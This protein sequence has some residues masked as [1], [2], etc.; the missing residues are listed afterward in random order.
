[1]AD[2]QL[3]LLG[4]FAGLGVFLGLPLAA[5]QKVSPKW[6]GFLNAFATGILIF[7]M[8]DA[9]GDAWQS[10]AHTAFNAFEGQ[11][12]VSDAVF[13]VLA[14]FGGLLIGLF[15]LAY[16]NRYM[17]ILVKSVRSESSEFHG[18]LMQE[19]L[20]EGVEQVNGCRLSLIIALGIG[21]HNFNEGLKLG[22]FYASGP[23]GLALSLSLLIG[24]LLHGA[25]KG[26]GI[27]GPL[28]GLSKM[29]SYRLLVATA[30]IC[31]LP[32]L[33]GTEIGGL[34]FSGLFFVFFM[35]VAAGALVYATAMQTL[36]LRGPVL[37]AVSP[38]YLLMYTA[39]KRQ[40]TNRILV[41]GVFFG[42]MAALTSNLLI[43]ISGLL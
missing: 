22:H 40:V 16:A 32:T 10:I 20:F 27:A 8:V 5:L 26:F 9:F 28:T 14:M 2:T 21:I 6:K 42:L 41:I 30:V 39:G 23:I 13:A 12:P 4:T 19:R 15:G 29:P 33:I 18:K 11:M 37:T 34:W 36:S 35:A 3:L 38:K 24:I 17:K 31:G 1:M 43:I 7:L 25:T